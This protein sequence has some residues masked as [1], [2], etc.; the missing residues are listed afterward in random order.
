MSKE[1][2]A[3]IQQFYATGQDR[4]DVGGS[5]HVVGHVDGV[6]LVSQEPVPQVHTLLLPP[7]QIFGFKHLAPRLV[8]PM[9]LLLDADP[10][11][12]AYVCRNTCI[13]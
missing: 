2:L 10:E 5:L 9:A 12:L 1:A 4:V 3:K 6:Q 8:K 13:F 7:T 11:H